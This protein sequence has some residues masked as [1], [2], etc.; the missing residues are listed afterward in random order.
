M[1]TFANFVSTEALKNAGGGLTSWCLTLFGNSVP[2]NSA[3]FPLHGVMAP[4]SNASLAFQAQSLGLDASPS[5]GRAPHARL[6]LSMYTLAGVDGPLP[7]FLS[8]RMLTEKSAGGSGLHAFLDLLNLRTWE[9][10]LLRDISGHDPRYV[11]FGPAHAQRLDQ[12]TQA[13]GQIRVPDH[14]DERTHVHR[15][16]LQHAF[17]AGRLGGCATNLGAVLSSLLDCKVEVRRHAP[18][19]LDIA[20]RCVIGLAANT[21]LNRGAALGDRAFVASGT[22]IVLRLDAAPTSAQA[23]DHLLDRANRCAELLFGPMAILVS[24]HIDVPGP[25]CATQLGTK[26]QQLGRLATLGLRTGASQTFCTSRMF[27]PKP[28]P[29][30]TNNSKDLS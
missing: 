7:L 23:C 13:V 8:E 15:L 29:R 5:A 14:F 4:A 2:I 6:I 27:N 16:L 26:G 11:G 3:S 30:F 1:K 18:V 21:R 25:S 22:E 28:F 19:R 12:L 9:L 24:F 20:R 10:V 17:T